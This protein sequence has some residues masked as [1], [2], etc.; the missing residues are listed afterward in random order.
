MRISPVRVAP[1]FAAR[2][3]VNEKKLENTL[4]KDVWQAV[5][6]HLPGFRQGVN[7]FRRSDWPLFTLRPFGKDALEGLIS[8]PGQ[9]N[10][11]GVATRYLQSGKFPSIKA[12]LDFLLK[13]A[14]NWFGPFP[15]RG[16]KYPPKP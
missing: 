4:R 7:Q 1:R 2:L 10:P 14:D 12:F 5:R 13:D 11:T 6:T 8:V 15:K 16:Q 9:I 3:D